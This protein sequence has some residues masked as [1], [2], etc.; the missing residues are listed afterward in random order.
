LYEKGRTRQYLHLDRPD[1]VR[2]E[3]QVRPAKQA[4]SSFATLTATE[5]WGASAW[6]RDL[7]GAVLQ[8]HVDPHPAGTVYRLSEREQRLR[9]CCHQ[10]GPT[11][12]ELLHELGSWEAVGTYLGKFLSAP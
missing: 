10:Y 6:T 1:W 7:A 5:V 11:F 9:W 8:Q 2:I 3:A 12:M 4:K